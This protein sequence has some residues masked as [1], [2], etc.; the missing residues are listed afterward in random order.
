MLAL[1][2]TSAPLT[3]SQPV[4]P[5]R[6]TATC[7]HSLSA[8]GA[9]P[10]S[11]CSRPLPEVVIANRGA[12]PALTVRNIPRAVLAPKSKILDHV[13]RAAGFAQVEIVKSLSPLTMPAG[14]LT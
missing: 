4:V 1:V 5:F 7:A 6:V 13:D 14:R 11:R 9:V 12:E 2:A 3:Y 8:C 10:L